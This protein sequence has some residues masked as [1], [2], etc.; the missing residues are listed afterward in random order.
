L[1]WS[2]ASIRSRIDRAELDVA[3]AQLVGDV[4]GHVTRLVL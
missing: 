3:S 4:H 2:I 1:A